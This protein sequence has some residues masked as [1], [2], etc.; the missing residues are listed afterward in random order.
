MNLN[1]A[2]TYAES[3]A[4]YPAGTVVDHIGVSIIGSAAGSVAQAQSVA[5]ATAS[6]TF[7]VTVADTYVY[8]VQAVDASGNSLGAAVIGTFA[9]VAPAL[10]SL[11]LPSAVTPSQ[12]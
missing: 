12:S 11:S 9:V 5:P 6:V 3:A 10:V 8:T 4:T 7:A 2:I 1:L